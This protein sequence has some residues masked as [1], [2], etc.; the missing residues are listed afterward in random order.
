MEEE[1][2]KK[3]ER[4]RSAIRSAAAGRRRARN[5][6]IFSERGDTVSFRFHLAQSGT[7]A[8][9]SLVWCTCY[10]GKIR[11]PIGCRD[12]EI[13]KLHNERYEVN[14]DQRANCGE[15]E[16]AQRSG[17]SLAYGGAVRILLF[18]GKPARASCLTI[19]TQNSSAFRTVSRRNNVGD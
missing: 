15:G 4:R 6:V 17:W 13:N 9:L 16:N 12:A 7:L 11:K 3:K 10:S 18:S 1:K 5:V 2:K 8:N 19:D 14:V